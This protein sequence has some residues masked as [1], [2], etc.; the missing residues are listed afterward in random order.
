MS[1]PSLPTLAD[2]ARKAKVSTATISRVLNSPDKVA[3]STRVKV[4]SAVDALGYSPN[5]QAKALVSNRTNTIG[6]VIP[7]MEN[8]IFARGLQAFQETITP[9]GVTLLVANSYYDPT[10]EE[11]Q[12]RAM[13][14]RG[15]DGLL[16]I[17]KTRSSKV[18]EFLDQRRVPYVIAWNYNSRTRY[19]CVGFDNKAAA[20]KLTQLS[21]KL[22]HR[23]FALI[24]A[25]QKSNDRARDRVTGVKQALKRAGLAAAET[26]VIEAPYSITDSGNAFREI[27][28]RHPNTT[29]VMCGN[30]V[31]AVGAIKMAQSMGLNVPGAISITGFDDLEIATVVQ[32]S[33]TTVHV[34]H[35]KMGT[36]AAELLLKMKSGET[37]IERIRL[38]TTIIERESLATPRK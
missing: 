24:S 33:V 36:K 29:I 34:P 22:G 5:F 20:E 37:K 18:Y 17:G 1:K 32:P 30:D 4:Q 10:I 2:V 31:Q 25:E 19:P 16:L 7:T 28:Q 26:P 21:L 13:I 12:I 14:A 8:A 3:E 27:I 35:Q 9:A 15:A 38:P 11:Q 23:N 6:A